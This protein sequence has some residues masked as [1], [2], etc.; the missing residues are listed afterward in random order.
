MELNEAFE[1]ALNE[2]LEDGIKNDLGMFSNR[3]LSDEEIAKWESLYKLLGTLFY[4]NFREHLYKVLNEN[5]D[6]V[7]G[8]KETKDTKEDKKV[9]VEKEKEN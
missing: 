5:Q 1:I 3:N 6:K 4:L 9:I 8:N 2:T 7:K